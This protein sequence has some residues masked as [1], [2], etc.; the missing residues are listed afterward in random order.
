MTFA[1]LLLAVTLGAAT[2]DVALGDVRLYGAVSNDGRDDTAAIQAALMNCSNTG[3]VVAIPIGVFTISVPTHGRFASLA[4]G[5]PSNCVLRG[6]DRNRSVLRFDSRVNIEN[7]WRMLGPGPLPASNITVHNFTI[8][9]NTNW[10]AYSQCKGDSGHCEHNAGLFFYSDINATGDGRA[11][12]RNIHIHAMNIHSVG[13]DCID[14]ANGVE[15]AVVEDITIRDFLR[16]GVDFGGDCVSRN[17]TARNITDDVAWQ[18]VTAPGGSTVH[19][20]VD[21]R[22]DGPRDVLIERN[23]CRHGLAAS[24]VVDGLTLR[25]NVVR[26]ALI[27]NVDGRVAIENNTVYC[28]GMAFQGSVVSVMGMHGGI[29]ANNTVVGG[30]DCPLFGLSLLGQRFYG[31]TTNCVVRGNAF[32]GAFRPTFRGQVLTTRTGI[33]LDGVNGVVLSATNRFVGA[34]HT[35]GGLG[36]NVCRC[37][38]Y[39]N[40]T[41]CNNVT[42]GV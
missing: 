32:V 39:H 12:I 18:S 8:D 15:N 35:A 9:G 6:T 19:V 33:N 25:H 4:L 30:P 5:I 27:A 17:F 29:I 7:W 28:D 16:Q 42:I 36:A 22:D 11:P 20:E 1:V 14:V 24:N 13:G 41:A 34:G 26:K 2:A 38:L 10:T 37:C 21:G 40:P 3:G 31:N 23:T